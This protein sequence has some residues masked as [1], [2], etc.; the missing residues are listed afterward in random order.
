MDTAVLPT[1]SPNTATLL[2]IAYIAST[3]NATRDT[4]SNVNTE[5]MSVQ[6]TTG[7]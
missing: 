5:S 7:N 1:T 3:V 6:T 2:S 4:S